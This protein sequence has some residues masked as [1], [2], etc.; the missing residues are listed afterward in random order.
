[1]D[2]NCPFFNTSFWQVFEKKCQVFGNFLTFNW[3]FSGGSGSKQHSDQHEHILSYINIVVC[4]LLNKCCYFVSFYP[5]I[6]VWSYHQVFVHE[7]TIIT[8]ISVTGKHGQFTYIQTPGDFL[9][10]VYNIISIKLNNFINKSITMFSNSIRI[11]HHSTK[12]IVQF[13]N[14]LSE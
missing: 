14:Y 1:M 6:V 3:Q 9:S 12:Y 5:A 2:K 13:C 10:V 11:T 7:I 4:R 8:F